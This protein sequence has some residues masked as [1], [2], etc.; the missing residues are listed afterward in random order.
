MIKLNAD[1]LSATGAPSE[2]GAA[3]I[4]EWLRSLLRTGPGTRRDAP[5]RRAR[6]R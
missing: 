3:Q 5:Y 6:G 2:G 1:N 4:E